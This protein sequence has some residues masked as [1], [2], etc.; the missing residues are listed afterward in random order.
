[1]RARSTCVFTAASP[2][3]GGRKGAGVAV[4]GYKTSPSNNNQSNTPTKQRLG[5]RLLFFAVEVAGRVPSLSRL[6]AIAGGPGARVGPLRQS[7]QAAE[8]LGACI[9]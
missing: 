1:M 8:A 4:L 9:G 5:Q 3:S 7:T 6:T 2:E